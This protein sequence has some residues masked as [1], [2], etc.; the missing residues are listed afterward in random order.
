MSSWMTKGRIDYCTV[1]LFSRYYNNV[2]W[3]KESCVYLFSEE[4][5]SVCFLLCL[6]SWR[7]KG[8]F[9]NECVRNT[10]NCNVGAND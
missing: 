5:P 10:N 1:I 7:K 9:Y 2:E 3:Q 4:S 8:R 6:E